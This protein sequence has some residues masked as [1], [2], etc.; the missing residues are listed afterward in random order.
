MTQDIAIVLVIL[1]VSVVLFI[2]EWVRVDVV[3]ML[4]LACL[5]ITGVLT[6]EEAL[7]GF[8]NTAVVTVWAILILSAALSRTG[9]AGLIGHRMLALAGT[10]EVRLTVI[11]M[12]TVGILSGF[13]NSIGVAALFLPVVIDISRQRNIPPSKL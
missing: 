1:G 3:A 12:L 5:A 4:V 13:M 2:T 10:S 6:P 9:V 8:S 7:S 11:I